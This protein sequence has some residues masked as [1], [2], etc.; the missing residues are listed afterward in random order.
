MDRGRIA[1]RRK[2]KQTHLEKPINSARKVWD[3]RLNLKKGEGL[4]NEFGGS[5]AKE[6]GLLFWF[7]GRVDG[8]GKY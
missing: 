4:V 2:I 1:W 8:R 7:C 3:L 5:E 6:Q